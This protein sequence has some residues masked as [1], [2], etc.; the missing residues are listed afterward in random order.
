MVSSDFYVLEI[1]TLCSGS[2]V[3]LIIRCMSFNILRERSE[4]PFR[5]NGTDTEQMYSKHLSV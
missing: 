2:V 4:S 1:Y 5:L 3:M